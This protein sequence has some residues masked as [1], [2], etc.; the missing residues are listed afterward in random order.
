MKE[1][2]LH[3]DEDFLHLHLSSASPAFFKYYL[4]RLFNNKNRIKKGLLYRVLEFV[5]SGS[6]WSKRPVLDGHLLEF[7]KNMFLNGLFVLLSCDSLVSSS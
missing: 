2:I 6:S 3:L 4:D 5:N 1:T 7:V